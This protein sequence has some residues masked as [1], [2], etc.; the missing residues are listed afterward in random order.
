MH[1]VQICRISSAGE[2]DGDGK[3]R[4]LV[5]EVG[6]VVAG[7]VV[8]GLIGRVRGRIGRI[9][10]GSNPEFTIGSGGDEIE[11]RHISLSGIAVTDRPAPAVDESVA[12]VDAFFELLLIEGFDEYFGCIGP[13]SRS[14]EML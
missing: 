6:D 4:L 14:T 11:P 5:H 3:V 10:C 9:I 2:T 7:P 12:A 1:F 13:K 8:I